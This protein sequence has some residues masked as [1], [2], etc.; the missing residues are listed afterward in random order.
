[1]N[2]LSTHRRCRSFQINIRSR[3]SRRSVP[4]RHT[5]WYGYPPN[6]HLLPEPHIVGGSTPD[7]LPCILPWEPSPELTKLPVVV[8]EQ[9]LGLVLEAGVPDLLFGSTRELDDQLPA[10]GRPFD[11]QAPSRRICKRDETQPCAAQRSHRTTRPWPGSSKSS[12]KL[13]N[14]WVPDAF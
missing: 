8:V 9:E 7:L 12:S 14:P 11:S 3:H 4:I 13:G 10:S 5:I 6:P 1:M 2:S